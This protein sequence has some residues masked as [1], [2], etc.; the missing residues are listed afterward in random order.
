MGSEKITNGVNIPSRT[1]NTHTRPHN[2]S[3]NTPAPCSL[4]SNNISHFTS[5]A[6]V[7]EVIRLESCDAASFQRLRVEDFVLLTLAVDSS[8]IRTWLKRVDHCWV[9]E[10]GAIIVF[11]A[12]EPA[13]KFSSGFQ[14]RSV[15]SHP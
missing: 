2:A 10:E 4:Y 7:L 8:S 11:V 14:T 3:V 12:V 13:A 6:L 15:Q 1:L 9:S 5:G